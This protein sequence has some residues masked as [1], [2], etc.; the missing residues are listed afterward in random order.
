MLCNV[1]AITIEFTCVAWYIYA[2]MMHLCFGFNVN[3]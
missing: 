1:F 2:K 3:E